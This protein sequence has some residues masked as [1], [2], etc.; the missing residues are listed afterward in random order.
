M[1]TQPTIPLPSLTSELTKGAITSI[2]AALGA[3]GIVSLVVGLLIL[4]WPGKTAIVVTAIIA[5]YAILA[6]LVYASIG[7][8]SRSSGGWA[9]VGHIALAVIFVAAGVITLGSL[10]QST[11]YLATF[12]GILVG[13]LWIIEGFVSLT[14]LGGAASKVWTVIFALISILAGIV[15]LTTPLWGAVVIWT[16]IGISLLILG[17]AQIVRAFTFGKDLLNA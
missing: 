7:L 17:I 12:L 1:S 6:G 4:I 13:I 8:F 16:V 3:V 9:R 5:I 11:A 10:G 14:N 2:R 15:L